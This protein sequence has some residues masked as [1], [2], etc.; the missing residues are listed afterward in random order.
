MQRSVDAWGGIAVPFF[1]YGG[2][3]SGIALREAE[4]GCVSAGARLG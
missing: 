1:T 3:S 2:I 4:V